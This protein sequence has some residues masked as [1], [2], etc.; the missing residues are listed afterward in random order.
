MAS[1]LMSTR[2]SFPVAKRPGREN[3]QLIT[4]LRLVP[5]LR[6]LTSIRP[7]VFMV[8]RSIKHRLNFALTIY[9]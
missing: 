4:N 7:Y 8:W 6:M 3:L 1:C 2:S 5:G 9:I